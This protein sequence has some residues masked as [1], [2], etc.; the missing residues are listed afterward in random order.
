MGWRRVRDCAEAL[1][2]CEG[3]TTV[4]S[5]IGVTAWTSARRPA[6]WMPSSLVTRIRGLFEF[7]GM[8]RSAR[9]KHLSKFFKNYRER[10]MVGTTGF[11]PATSRTP[12]VRATRLRY[13][14][15]A[16]EKGQDSEKFFVQIEEEFALRARG[17]LAMSASC[18][19]VRM[20]CT[21]FASYAGVCSISGGLIGE[22]FAGTDDGETLFVEKPLDFENGF[23]VLAAIKAMSTGAFHGLKRGNSVS[24]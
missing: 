22:M 14:P 24:Q 2:S 9:A 18:R 3:A 4:T 6:A 15:T 23:D 17:W 13:V 21:S 20:I 16:F 5:P 1:R 10:K 19:R 12:S 7:S 11:E 8:E